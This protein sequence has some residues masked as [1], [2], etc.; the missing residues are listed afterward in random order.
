M[1]LGG[2]RVSARVDER[3]QQHR[4]TADG[5]IYLF[6]NKCSGMGKLVLNLFHQ[7]ATP[8]LRFLECKYSNT[9]R[10]VRHVCSYLLQAINFRICCSHERSTLFTVES[11]TVSMGARK[12]KRS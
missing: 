12:S 10:C 8:H 1:L 3:C 2:V 11:E 5:G 4:D 6:G 7:F 9:N